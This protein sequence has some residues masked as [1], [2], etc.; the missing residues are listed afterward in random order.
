MCVGAV[1]C[2]VYGGN[3]FLTQQMAVGPCKVGAQTV[4]SG[5]RHAAEKVGE[6]ALFGFVVGIHVQ[7]HHDEYWHVAYES[8]DECTASAGV[9]YK[10]DERIA[11]GDCSVEVEGE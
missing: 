3:G 8:A 10:L 5:E 9:A 1:Q 11:C 4:E 7:L 6:Y 2:S